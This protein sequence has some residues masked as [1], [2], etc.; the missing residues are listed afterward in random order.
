MI[1]GAWYQVLRWKNHLRDKDKKRGFYSAFSED[2]TIS[3]EL[4]GI[5]DGF[6]VDIGSGHP[7]LDS[8]SYYFY[9]NLNWRG[10]A[11]DAIKS[12]VMQH[13]MFRP[14]DRAVWAAVSEKNGELTVYEYPANEFTTT[15]AKRYE[16]L[17][18]ENKFPSN[19][20]VLN[21]YRLELLLKEE[22]KICMQESFM[23]I[24]VE[25]GERDV[26]LSINWDEYRPTLICI[27]DISNTNKDTQEFLDE[28]GYR[29]LTRLGLSNIYRLKMASHLICGVN[30][31]CKFKWSN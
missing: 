28:K 15:D 22:S 6:Y 29:L 13:K 30:A 19:I 2:S 18:L 10:L 20:R 7:I 11:V 5:T 16:E 23:S 14:H 26:L 12:N 4:H 8:N 1:R 9:K 24:D 17:K 27:E 3:K 25:G 31:K 21:S